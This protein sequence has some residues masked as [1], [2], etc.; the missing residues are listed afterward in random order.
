M[1]KKIFI[2]GGAIKDWEST[3]LSLPQKGWDI[4]FQYR[5]SKEQSDKITD[6]LNKERSKSC[7]ALQCDFDNKESSEQFNEKLCLIKNLHALI[8]NAST[9]Y[10]KSLKE[11]TELDWNSSRHQTLQPIFITKTCVG[12]LV[13]NKGSIVNIAYI[14]A[15]YR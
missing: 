9:F 6:E 13:K 4:I 5:S 14:H 10:P 15:I 1:N 11:S 3:C 2:S 8:N 12:E 7:M